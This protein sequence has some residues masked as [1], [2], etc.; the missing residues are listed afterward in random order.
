[1]TTT[2]NNNYESHICYFLD[3]LEK[4]HAFSLALHL[5]EGWLKL[6]LA[7]HSGMVCT[8]NNISYSEDK[9]PPDSNLG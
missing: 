5:Q 2:N 9:I 8:P 7:S 1:M 4:C 6:S 3:Y